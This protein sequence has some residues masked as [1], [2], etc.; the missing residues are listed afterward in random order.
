VFDVRGR[1]IST[2]IDGTRPAGNHSVSFN[3]GQLP[4]G[5]YVY[6]IEAPEGVRTRR[7]SLV[8]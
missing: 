8:R 2:L 3:A 6:R 5:V 4:S 7:M 1:L